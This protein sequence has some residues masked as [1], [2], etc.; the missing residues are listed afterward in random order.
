MFLSMPRMGYEDYKMIR[1]VKRQTYLKNMYVC[2]PAF[3]LILLFNRLDLVSILFL[4]EYSHLRIKVRKQ[5]IM[6]IRPFRG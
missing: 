3:F 5:G 2:F 6:R 4:Q 1:I